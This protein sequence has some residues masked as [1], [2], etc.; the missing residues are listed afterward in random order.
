VKDSLKLTVYFGESDRIGHR[1]VSDELFDAFERAGL[2]AAVLMRAVEGFGIKHKLRTQRFLTLSEDLPLVAVAVDERAAIEAV[3]PDVQQL[4]DGGLITL[5]RARLSY[6]DLR[7]ADV[8]EELHEETKLTLYLG[9]DERHGDKPAYLAVVDHLC[10]HGLAGATVLLGVDGISH[11]RRQRARFFARNAAVPLMVAS[12]GHADQIAGALEGL[13]GVLREPL[14]TL[15]R[16]RVCKRD[17][18]LLAEPRHLPEQDDAGL[19]I[20]QKLM[21]YAGEQARH[22]GHPLY[23]Q[24]I[25]RLREENASGATAVRGIWGFSGDHA[26][27]GDRLLSVRRRVP[28]VTTLVDS[29]AEIRRWFAIV[30]ELTDEAGLVTSELVPAFHAVGPGQRVG[31]LRLAR[32]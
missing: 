6:G 19:G 31:G 12:V 9:R 4:I 18:M 27:H 11:G 17:G 2:Q 29:P 24:L 15:E 1:L 21:V 23:I 16:V 3:L 30:D 13:G 7:G 8:A 32:P 28:V 10:R 26:P 20:W 22:E 14:L 5:E 25:R